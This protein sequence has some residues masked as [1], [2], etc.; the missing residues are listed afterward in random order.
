M[1]ARIAAIGIAAVAMACAS[2]PVPR[3]ATST[4]T[5]ATATTLTEFQQ[6]YIEAL[7]FGTGPFTPAN[8]FT[9]VRRN[10]WLGFP[11]G[12]TVAVVI[13]RVVTA[14]KRQAI[15]DAADQVADAT[16]G[17]ITATVT[18]TD[19]PNPLPAAHQVTSTTMDD[20]GTQ[21]CRT[22][23]GCTMFQMAAPAILRSSRAVQLLTVPPNN[24]SHDVIGHGVLGL[25]HIDG[26]AIGGFAR[27]LMSDGRGRPGDLINIKLTDLD[28]AA[29]RAVFGSTLH[30]GAA[31]ADFARVGLVRP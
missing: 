1:T 17:A 5:P 2:A 8:G 20:P 4:A 3:P 19:D 16:A 11:R 10:G 12:T 21:G 27:S 29:L 15:E 28:I 18:L 22:G 6:D 24:Y 30:P 31:R 13:S 7:F 25:C 9:C 26:T 23:R 14:D